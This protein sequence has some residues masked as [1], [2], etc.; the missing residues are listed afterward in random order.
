MPRKQFRFL[1]LRCWLLSEPRHGSPLGHK[2][3]RLHAGRACWSSALCGAREGS[4]RRG[5]ALQS[6]LQSFLKRRLS[7]LLD[8]M[9]QRSKLLKWTLTSFRCL[10]DHVLENSGERSTAK[11]GRGRFLWQCLL[12]SFVNKANNAKLQKRGDDPAPHREGTWWLRQWSH[13]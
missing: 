2:A 13:N 11:L 7:V 4:T 6:L 10:P 5:G 12:L 8:L 1:H 9:L 3:D